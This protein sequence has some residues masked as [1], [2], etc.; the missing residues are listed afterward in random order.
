[1]ILTFVVT[2]VVALIGRGTG[3]K[4]YG[5]RE[6]YQKNREVSTNKISPSLTHLFYRT[7]LP[8]KS[9]CLMTEGIK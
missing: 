9:V 6:K 4:T 5:E 7:L 8:L 1:M 3:C 2:G